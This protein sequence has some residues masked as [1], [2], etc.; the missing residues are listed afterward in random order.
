MST[1]RTYEI[2]KANVA[3][4][5]ADEINNLYTAD[6]LMTE[7]YGLLKRFRN[8]DEYENA[9]L[10]AF[11]SETNELFLLSES[12]AI[13]G[14]LTLMKGTDWSGREQYK[15]TIRLCGTTISAPMVECLRQFTLKK[16]EL[17]K[18][19]AIIVYGSELEELA[20]ALSAKVQLKGNNYTLAKTDVNINMLKEASEKLQAKNNDLRIVYT[21]TMPEEYIEQ[22]CN[23]FNELQES[24]PD[25]N[26]D[27]FV[28]YIST[29]EKLKTSLKSNVDQ[30]R[31]RHC[32]MIFN[33]NNEMIAQSNV[34]VNNN[35]PRF[36]YQFLIGVAKCYR[37]RSLGKWLYAAMYQKL[38]SDVA[39][40]K[41]QIA[42]HPS[43]KHVIAI[44]EWAGYKFAFLETM[45]VVEAD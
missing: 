6:S 18:Y 26:E 31:T 20:N 25:V 9:F 1:N 32:Y 37:G 41:V 19:I 17:H 21:N 42:H 7:K 12:G 14:I 8:A 4:M 22:Y 33:A 38:F 45:Y 2:V 24:M 27:G 35:D 15:L 40:E 29:P 10:P 34:A 28:Q 5:Q 43:N 30:N 11:K 36:P 23:L 16:L 39:F 3:A 13:T 44:S